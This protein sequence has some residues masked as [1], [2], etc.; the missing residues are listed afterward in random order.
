MTRFC[1][2]L[3]NIPETV[4]LPLNCRNPDISRNHDAADAARLTLELAERLGTAPRLVR[5]FTPAVA[6]ARRTLAGERG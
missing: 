4:S 5:A 2:D 3:S 1:D 6:R